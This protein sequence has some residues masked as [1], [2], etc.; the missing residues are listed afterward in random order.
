MKDETI[1]DVY[2]HDELMTSLNLIK[3]GFG[4]LQNLDFGNDF[5]H[6]PFQL[7]SSGLERLMKCHIC[8]GYHE[9]F[10]EFPDSKYLRKCGGSNGHDLTI[11]KEKILLEYFSNQK[12]PAL[13]DDENILQNDK[14][15]QQLIYLLSEFGKYARYHNL[16]IVTSATKP[17]IDVKQLWREFETEILLADTK[18]LNKLTGS[19]YHYEVNEFVTQFTISKLEKFVRALS[20]QFTLGGLGKKAKQFSP[21]FFEFIMLSDDGIGITDYRKETTRYKR[22][23]TKVH[24]RNFIDNLKRRSNPDIKFKRINKAD[25]NGDWPFYADEVIIECRQKNWCVIEIE[26]HDYA[27]NGVAQG[28]LNLTSVQDAGV[29]IYGKSLTPFREMALKLADE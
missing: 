8:L 25:F 7:L 6:L 27:L 9:R 13:I 23:E 4:E 26:G 1:K 15:L 11:L 10:N 22:K 5:Y 2:L 3:L 20:R 24:K 21:V 16:D 14:N 17:S 12:I 19:E 29:A 28:R 18:L